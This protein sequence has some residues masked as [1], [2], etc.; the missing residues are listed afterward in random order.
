MVG[1]LAMSVSRYVAPE[2]VEEILTEMKE[3]EGNYAFMAGGTIV[4]PLLSSG[5]WLPHTVIGLWRA[6]LAAVER[7]N[8]TIAIG[9]GAN[10]RDLASHTLPGGLS[11]AAR[12]V[13]APAIRN[14]ATLGGNIAIG[15]GDLIV[16]LLALDAWVT[17]MSPSGTRDTPISEVLDQATGELRDVAEGHLLTRVLVPA[18]ESSS[19]YVA[20]GRKSYNTPCVASVSVNAS[21]ESSTTV[22]TGLK[23][24]VHGPQAWPVRAEAVEQ[25]LVG[26]GLDDG[27]IR[28]AEE[29]M[30]S[31]G[32]GYSDSVAS[33]WY[34]ASM[35][36]V[37]LRRA[38]AQLAKGRP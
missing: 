32:D 5:S 10:M 9:A 7:E 2:S 25:V 20:I 31:V 22:L 29:A 23:V 8:G 28:E 17:L 34:R 11:D 18:T 38:L 21:F 4:Q 13:G 30:S 36:R 27:A 12:Q 37:V 6:P 14:R 33:A 19:A 35:S 16:P 26:R 24:A 3:Q 15:R 1:E